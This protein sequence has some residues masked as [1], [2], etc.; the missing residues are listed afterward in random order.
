MNEEELIEDARGK[1]EKE[2]TGSPVNVGEGN[3]SDELAAEEDADQGNC[4]E[5]QGGAGKDSKG[6]VLLGGET[7]GDQLGLVSQF[8]QEDHAEGGNDRPPSLEPAFFRLFLRG[9]VPFRPQ[10]SYPEKEEEERRGKLDPDHML[11]EDAGKDSAGQHRTDVE[12]GKGSGN[13][14]KGPPPGIPGR[15][16]HGGKLGLVPQFGEEDEAEGGE[17]YGGIHG[18]S[19]HSFPDGI[20]WGGKTQG[21]IAMPRQKLLLTFPGIIAYHRFRKGE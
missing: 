15:Q 4:P 7:G 17:E 5:G 11:A 13:P 19:R 12:Q 9:I 16:G 21:R 2:C 10:G 14:D 6:G 18:A 1:D 3:E 8:S 20:G